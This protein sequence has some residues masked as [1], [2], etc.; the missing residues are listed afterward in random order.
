[1]DYAD[2]FKMKL[3]SDLENHI[4]VDASFIHILFSVFFA[5]IAASNKPM[6]NIDTI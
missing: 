5:W 4:T 1:M 2:S 6:S 3:K